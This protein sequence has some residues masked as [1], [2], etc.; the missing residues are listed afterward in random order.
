MQPRFQ[1]EDVRRVA[2]EG[3]QM[4]HDGPAMPMP[5]RPPAGSEPGISQPKWFIRQVVRYDGGTGRLGTMA[6]SLRALETYVSGQAELI[7]GY[8][9]ARHDGELISTTTTEATV[10]W[11]LHRRMGANRQ[12]RWSPRGAH[13]MLKVRT[14]VAN[15]TL[16]EDHVA[17]EGWARRPF[18]RAA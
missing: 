1:L 12:M 6:V 4:R 15:G 14:A 7:I 17:A 11:L 5:Q 13:R 18:R 9:E 16:A 10:R 3:A 2:T 8:A